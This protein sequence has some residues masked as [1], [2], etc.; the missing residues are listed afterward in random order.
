MDQS[1]DFWIDG[2]GDIRGGLKQNGIE[3]AAPDCSQ[4]DENI[5]AHQA[6][7]TLLELDPKNDF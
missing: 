7:R 5:Q 6:C 3:P 4:K 2:H 1:R